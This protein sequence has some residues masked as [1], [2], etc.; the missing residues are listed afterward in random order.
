MTVDPMT[1]DLLR[2]LRHRERHRA[3]DAHTRQQRRYPL[4][5]IYRKDILPRRKQDGSGPWARP[6]VGRSTI[7]MA[8]NWASDEKGGLGKLWRARTSDRHSTAG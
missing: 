5:H 6:S 4:S 2:A 8:R 1:T 7:P 3:V